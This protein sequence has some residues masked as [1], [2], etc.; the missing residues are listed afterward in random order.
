MVVGAALAVGG[1]GGAVRGARL[2][3][4][5]LR[6]LL[7]LAGRERGRHRNAWF[8]ERPVAALQRV[9]RL[10]EL[11]AVARGG[12]AAGGLGAGGGELGRIGVGRGR[13]DREHRPRLPA[14]AQRRVGGEH[15]LA[16]PGPEGGGD[17]DRR[18]PARRG[19]VFERAVVGVAG[20]PLRGALVE[21][22]EAR[23]QPRRQ[24]ARAQ[25]PGAE[26][27]DRA[28]PARVHLARVLLLAQRQEAP[29]D[30]VAELARGLLGE[31][32]REDRADRHPVLQHRLHA[33]LGHHRGLAR[34]GVGGEQRGAVA[35][36]DR[37]ALLVGE[38][39]GAGGGGEGGRGH[40][41][42][43]QI[44]GYAQ[45]LGEHLSGQARTSPARSAAAV[46]SAFERTSESATSIS[47]AETLSVDT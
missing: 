20:E 25:H 6:A 11:L 23:V 12:E 8:A 36:L 3:L 21:H 32:E 29:A 46:S 31:R 37:R 47:S 28:D 17:V 42:A 22:L 33:P 39:D 7:E 40:P 18:R 43:R 34:A 4:E 30:A 15:E 45:P 16:Q 2:L 10:L 13:R 38:R 41:P 24:R 19:P 9:E 1:P 14:R 27:V 26:A 5:R 44:V 35:V